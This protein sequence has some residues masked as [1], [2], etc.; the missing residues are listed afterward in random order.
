MM[1]FFLILASLLNIF[2]TAEE[3]RREDRVSWTTEST[4]R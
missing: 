2:V 1:K 3:T 4:L